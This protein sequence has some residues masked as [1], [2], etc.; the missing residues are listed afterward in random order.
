M[1]E[2]IIGFSNSILGINVAILCKRCGTVWMV[3]VTKDEWDAFNHQQKSPRLT[4]WAMPKV[5]QMLLLNGICEVCTYQTSGPLSK[6]Q[7]IRNQPA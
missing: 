6:L 2:H 3:F 4:L 7:A 5:D 1:M